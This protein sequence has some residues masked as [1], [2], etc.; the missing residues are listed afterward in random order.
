MPEHGLGNSP[1]CFVIRPNGSG[2]A[3]TMLSGGCLLVVVGAVVGVGL[4]YLDLWPV[5]L[6]VSVTMTALGV[7]AWV[8]GVR[9][10]WRQ[11]ISIDSDVVGVET[12]QRQ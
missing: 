1:C 8:V 4:V 11:V 7:A 3:V 6:W 10:K 2:R 12:G 9:G 5:G